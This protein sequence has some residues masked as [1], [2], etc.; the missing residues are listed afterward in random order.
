MRQ[1]LKQADGA[2]YRW[3]V[4]GGRWLAQALAADPEVR[5][6]LNEHLKSLAEHMAPGFSRFLTR[7]ISDTVKKWDADELASQIEANIGKDLQAIRVNG[8]VVGGAIG[9]VLYLTSL[10]PALLR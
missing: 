8:T 6:S 3:L 1:D 2:V 10:L 5:N 4:Q 9:L 7:H